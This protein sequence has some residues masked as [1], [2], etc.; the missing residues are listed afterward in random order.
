MPASRCL[1]PFNPS[2]STPQRS[3]K[4]SGNTYR[5]LDRSACSEPCRSARPRKS[6]L[7]SKPGCEN[8]GK[9]EGY[10]WRR[11]TCCSRTRP[12][13]TLWPFS[14]PSIRAAGPPSQVEPGWT[15]RPA[16][17]ERNAESSAALPHWTESMDSSGD[18]PLSRL[19]PS[20]RL[21]FQ[22]GQELLHGRR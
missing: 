21:F 17:E 10:C 9:A 20:E 13:K 14:R 2:A 19:P 7:K 12:G 6:G 8:W 18:A 16:R 22:N 15:S 11:R 4:P 5:F 1:T 3:R